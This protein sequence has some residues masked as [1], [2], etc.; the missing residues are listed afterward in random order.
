V[1]FSFTWDLPT[2][3]QG[4]VILTVLAACVWWVVTHRGR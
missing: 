4:A 2:I 3:L 1:R